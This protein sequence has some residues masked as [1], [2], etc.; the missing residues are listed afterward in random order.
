MTSVTRSL[1]ETV[2]P[3]LLVPATSAT[4][5]AIRVMVWSTLATALY[6]VIQYPNLPWLLPVQFL[7]NGSAS[8]WQFRTMPRVLMP[9]FVQIA[10]AFTLGGITTLLLSRK[11]GIH[12]P[13]ASD[14][15]AARTAAEAVA[16]IGAIWVAFQGYAA[17]AL[18]A[19]WISGRPGLGDLY[20]LLQL[21]GL[22]LTGIV[23]TRAHVRL[24]RPKARPYVADHWWFGHF[25]R[26]VD[27]PALFVPTRE[28]RRWTLNFG[29]P[30]AVVLMG[31]ILAVGA[32]GPTI[33]IG[34]ALR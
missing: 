32:L 19:M 1:T 15:R 12:D 21:L 22:V 10:L 20:V 5:F 11:R 9:V 25:Y 8:G 24:G 4:R 7:P 18:V 27:D 23:A 14:V 33:L 3:T 16:L 29:R 34:L 2:E 28:G 6:L 13:R 17:I 30:G 31:F 26:N